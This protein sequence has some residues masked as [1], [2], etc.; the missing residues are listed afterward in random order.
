MKK[1]RRKHLG[2]KRT[3]KK[4]MTK[5]PREKIELSEVETFDLLSIHF[6]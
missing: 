2:R 4:R 1:S 6:H 3:K 5:A